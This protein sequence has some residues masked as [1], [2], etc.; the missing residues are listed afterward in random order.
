MVTEQP[1]RVLQSLPSAGGESFEYEVRACLGGECATT[2]P[3]DLA[4]SLRF[5]IDAHFVATQEA[6]LTVSRVDQEGAIVLLEARTE[7]PVGQLVY[8]NGENCPPPPC[9]IADLALDGTVL[10]PVRHRTDLPI[11]RLGDL[12][13]RHRWQPERGLAPN[14]AVKPSRRS[15]DGSRAVT[16]SSLQ[17]RPDFDA[18]IAH[19]Q[20]HR[21]GGGQLKNARG[22]GDLASVDPSGW[23]LQNR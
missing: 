5:I 19:P 16:M 7:N 20:P 23:P 22:S 2:H 13:V 4:S 12:Y 15:A 9:L 11:S 3:T 18:Q 10:A 6:S 8:P 14:R 1:D 21:T 17:P